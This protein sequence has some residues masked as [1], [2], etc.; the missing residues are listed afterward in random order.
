VRQRYAEVITII[1]IFTSV[2][3]TAEDGNKKKLKII[4]VLLQL[5]SNILKYD[6]F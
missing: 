5:A 2:L 4:G 1:N 3:K 6:A